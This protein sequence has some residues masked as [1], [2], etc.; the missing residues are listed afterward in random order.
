MNYNI[1]YN[2]PIELN[3]RITLIKFVQKEGYTLKAKLSHMR[4]KLNN[5]SK[6]NRSIR[7][8][9]IYNKW[10][11]D[12]TELNSYI[13]KGEAEDIIKKIIAD[14]KSDLLLLHSKLDNEK[15]LYLSNK[16][17]HLYRNIKSIEEETGVHDFY[18]GYP[19]L[20][21]T[22]I[23]G[24]FFQAPLF[25][26]PLRLERN[27]VN[28]QK[29]N[30]KS[31]NEEPQVNRTLFLALKKMNGFNFTED[32][33]DELGELAR[34]K[35]FKQCFEKLKELDSKLIKNTENL[36]KLQEYRKE[37]I[38]EQKNMVLLNHAILGHFPQGGSAI[39]KDY[40]QLIKDQEENSL[41]LAE[42]LIKSNDRNTFV[43]DDEDWKEDNEEYRNVHDIE[44]QNQL[45]LL[46]T[47]GSQEDI[48]KEARFQQ[49]L[50]VY[51]PPG[52]GKSQ[53]I[54]NL[55]TDALNQGKKILVVCQKRAALDV[56]YQRLESVNL[57]LYTALIHDE[58]SDRKKLYT[59][60]DSTLNQAK[61]NNHQSKE[62]LEE[63]SSK[64]D[65]H[66]NMLNQIAKVLYTHQ[67]FG[68]RLYD[69][70]GMALPME[71]NSTYLDVFSVM[72]QFNKQILE[73]VAKD[74]YIYAEWYEKFGHEKYLLKNRSSYSKM[75]IKNKI[76][77]LD[78]FNDL[79]GKCKE[80]TEHIVE[81]DHN[82]ITP[83]YTWMIQRKL[84]KINDDLID[85]QSGWIVNFRLWIWTRFTGK[86]IIKELSTDQKFNGLQ[87]V[88]WLRIRKQL[89]ILS[90]LAIT[91]KKISISLNHLKDYIGSSVINNLQNEVAEG[92]IPTVKLES[93]LTCFHQDF[94]DIKQ[95]D[96]F[97][98][99]RSELSKKI[100]QL[101]QQK[102]LSIQSEAKEFGLAERW[103]T[104]LRNSIYTYWI[105]EV[106]QKHPEVQKISTNEFNRIRDQF[107]QLLDAKKNV[108]QSYLTHQIG[109]NIENLKTRKRTQIKEL[110][111]QVN[112]KR[113]VWPLRRLVDQYAVE[114]LLDILPVW[115]TSPETASSIFPL[116]NGL[117]DVVIFDEAS[118]CTVESGIPAVFR[119]KQVIVAGDEKQL[120]PFTAFRAS[121]QNDEDEEFE[122]DIDESQ[123]LLNLAKRKF[124]IRMLQ[125]HYR[126]KSEEL[127]NFSNHAFYDG[128]IQIA[129]SVVPLQSPPNM[130]WEKVNGRWIN[131]SNE[132]EAIKIVDL[133][134]ELLIENP[135]RSIGV[136]T[137]NANQQE[138]VLDTI[139]KRIQDDEEFNALYQAVMSKELDERIF[140][141]NI[142]NVQGDERDIIIFSIGF[143]KNEE[144]KMYN[145][146]GSLNQKNGENRLNVAIT[147]AKEK[148]IVVTSIEPEELNVTN[149]E[150]I[151]PK[152][153]KS[154]LKY[155]QSVAKVN[156]E[157]ITQVIQEIS[158]STNT[159]VQHNELQ[160]DS[161]F[162]EQVY[163]KL[164]ILGYEITTQVG[165]SGYRIDLAVVH[166]KDPQK[167]IIG[168]ECDGAMY[169]SSQSAKERD[170]Y[171]QR[172]L[173]SRGW[174]IER[175][176]SRNWWKNPVREIELIDEKI[177]LLIKQ[178]ETQKK[179]SSL[180]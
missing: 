126:S 121:T 39:V 106:E 127:I 98:E 103:T 52:T 173:E 16:L 81:L 135:N 146:F 152:L 46:P 97:Y 44:E 115:L 72:S 74:I 9:K 11:F 24:T 164:S 176:W 29:W 66:Q 95:M 3:N 87:S 78:L 75:D 94:D 145:R 139:D 18:L 129:P 33:L 53:V 17:T 88:E 156:H 138:K 27:S 5:I 60:I 170:V 149:T 65:F 101:L 160:F 30:L 45:Y 93:F 70:Y 15:S 43:D 34:E 153:L 120:A 108:A 109:Q 110:N 2:D 92:E 73:E 111:H 161:P 42:I 118:Q 91:T 166:P 96:S 172:F 119:G 150:N 23:D 1:F 20:S 165:M 177:K 49:G 6:R 169:H 86:S 51:G 178:E 83:A 38:P 22:M 19:F 64:I 28:Q 141:K 137:F 79:I 116:E 163:E 144:G 105:N 134:T 151:G 158:Q 162:E 142:E 32:W 71:E 157:Q 117:F 102:E 61:A 4:D 90:D 175:I 179:I 125:W 31:V 133:L 174:Q 63:L 122:Y 113:Q 13:A 180:L 128:H 55:I 26:Y 167:Y 136:I 89:K 14:S 48:L 69:L 76:E 41:G 58:K 82:T 147:R 85:K 62:D 57:S 80:A 36:S 107:A 25:L 130:L 50:V 124:P 59:Q 168:I 47:D 155:V 132:V 171:R 8:L 114:G 148:I 67:R 159:Q 104:L 35:D 7:L 154:Y 84:E 68:Y 99:S 112:K 40:E 10:S 140:V 100:I 123:S 37:E 143:A 54:V 77:T 131:T 21:G 56:I 12:L